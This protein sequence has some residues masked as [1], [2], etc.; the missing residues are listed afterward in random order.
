MAKVLRACTTAISRNNI[1]EI[2]RDNKKREVLTSL[3]L[4]LSLILPHLCSYH[5]S[6]MNIHMIEKSRLAVWK[7]LLRF[8]P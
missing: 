2:E 7:V 6:E 1:R 8:A 5:Q 4:Y 3:F